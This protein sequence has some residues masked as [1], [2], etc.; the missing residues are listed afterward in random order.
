M[1][2]EMF[3]YPWDLMDKLCAYGVEHVSL[4]ALY[5]QARLLLP[6][7]PR[8]KLLMHCVVPETRDELSL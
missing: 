5:H 7:N 4:A 3:L 1:V 2:R 8:R 6:H